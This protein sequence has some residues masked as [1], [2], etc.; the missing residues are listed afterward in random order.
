MGIDYLFILSMMNKI[1][2]EIIRAKIIFIKLAI[3]ILYPDI[4]NLI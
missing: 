1:P 3:N 2:P 4:D